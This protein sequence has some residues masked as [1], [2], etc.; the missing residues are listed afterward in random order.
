MSRLLRKNSKELSL[1]RNETEIEVDRELPKY[2]NL[3][4]ETK[5]I[6][7]KDNI[8]DEVSGDISLTFSR[9]VQEDPDSVTSDEFM[10]LQD[11][12]RKR[13]LESISKMKNFSEVIGAENAGLFNIRISS[14]LLKVLKDHGP[15]QR[16]SNLLLNAESN[17]NREFEIKSVIDSRDE[18]KETFREKLAKKINKILLGEPKKEKTKGPEPQD[19]EK[20]Y[21]LSVLDLFDQIKIISGQERE[22]KERTETYMSLIQKSL[23]LHQE[24]QAE[25]LISKLTIHI[26]ESVLAT[27]GFNHYIELKDLVELQLKCE[28][29]LDLDYIKNFVRIIPDEVVEKKV[30][31]DNLQVFDN[32]VVL[33]Y[34]PNKKAFKLTE[35]EEEYIKR[36]P[37]LFGVINSSSKLYYVAD[38]MDEYC[39]LTWDQVVEKLGEDKTL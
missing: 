25:E 1:F 9:I 18:K 4:K 10:F 36:D 22:F 2:K 24:A 31:A 32:Y 16:I 19:P 7:S 38:W 13:A 30:I 33:Y 20:V 8:E 26:Y 37:I 34:D 23:T 35:Q 39:D 5:K 14:Y 15:R 29:E 12:S 27:S 6:G 3:I 11:E 21:E 28:K 17:M